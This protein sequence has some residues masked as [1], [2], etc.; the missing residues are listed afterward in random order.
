MERFC[1][2]LKE[3]AKKKKKKISFEKKEMIPL[4]DEEISLIKSRK[5]VIYAKKDLVLM[6]M[7]KS[8]IKSEIIATHRKI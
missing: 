5:Y 8:I 7:I 4:N 3:H 1:K 2:D 6:M